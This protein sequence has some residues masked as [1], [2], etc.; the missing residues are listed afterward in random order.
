VCGKG[1]PAASLTALARY[2]VRAGAI[3]EGQPG[4]V[5]RLLNRAILDAKPGPG[6]PLRALGVDERFCTIA[7]AVVEPA[8]GSVKLTLACAGHPLPQL[9]R[10]SGDVVAVGVPGTMVGLFE[11]VELVE[12]PVTL[13]PGDALVFYTDGYIEARS[14]GGAFAPDLIAEALSGAVGASAEEIAAIIDRAVAAFEDGGQRDDRAL[15]VLKVPEPS[16]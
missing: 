16:G 15:L 12:V 1:A 3:D 11:E 9:L 13:E 5:L 14:P 2:T 7:F 4:N 6:D 8:A 10:S